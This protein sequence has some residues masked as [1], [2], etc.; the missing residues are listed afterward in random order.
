[1]MLWSISS[2]G[3]N[4]SVLQFIYL[5]IYLLDIEYA[6]GSSAW[7]CIAW[8]TIVERYMNNELEGMWKEAAVT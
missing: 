5:F 6:V 2:N 4:V 3:G 8:K 7:A 1:M